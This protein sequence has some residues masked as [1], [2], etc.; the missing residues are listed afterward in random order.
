MRFIKCVPLFI[1]HC[2][3]V[4]MIYRFIVVYKRDINE[5]YAWKIQKSWTFPE[6]LANWHSVRE[7][8]WQ[9]T[10]EIMPTYLPVQPKSGAWLKILPVSPLGLWLDDEG[11]H[12]AVGF[13]L[14]TPL[15]RPHTCQYC[16]MEVDSLAT[17][18]LSC[19]WSEGC[20]HVMGYQWR[21]AQAF[22]IHLDW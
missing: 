9:L 6:V 11:V 20:H 7:S 21:S 15:C 22:N 5:V 8:N 10:A 18:S 12:V 16:G 17:P 19:R 4:A 3:D 13:R 14:G 2:Q 1:T